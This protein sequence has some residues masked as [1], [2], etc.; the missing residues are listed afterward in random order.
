MEKNYTMIKQNRFHDNV[1]SI[2]FKDGLKL[3]KRKFDEPKKENFV[4]LCLFQ[5]MYARARKIYFC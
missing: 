1:T 2:L 5:I 3:N 4:S